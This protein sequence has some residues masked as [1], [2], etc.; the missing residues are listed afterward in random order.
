MPPGFSQSPSLS[1]HTFA[2]STLPNVCWSLRTA[3]S[4]TVRVLEMRNRSY[5]AGSNSDLSPCRARD[6]QWFCDLKVKKVFLLEEHDVRGGSW[7]QATGAQM[8]AAACQSFLLCGHRGSHG[9]SST[10]ISHKGKGADHMI[11]IQGLLGCTEG[12]LTMSHVHLSAESQE[13][14]P[15]SFCLKPSPVAMPRNTAY[16]HPLFP[17]RL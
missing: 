2:D 3:G 9:H 1:S 17:K 13:L 15:L 6:H 12:I 7:N 11:L 5:Q 16:C 10:Y 14:T 8:R 4:T